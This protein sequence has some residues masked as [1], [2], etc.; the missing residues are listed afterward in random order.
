MISSQNPVLSLA[1]PSLQMAAASAH[2]AEP[3]TSEAPW[4]SSVPSPPAPAL[5]SH[6]VLPVSLLSKHSLVRLLL[7]LS[8]TTTLWV[9]TIPCRNHCQQ[10]HILS[11]FYIPSF[12]PS[13][14]FSSCSHSLF[15]LNVYQPAS[16]FHTLLPT[17][18]SYKPPIYVT[19]HMLRMEGIL[20]KDLSQGMEEFQD[21][22]RNQHQTVLK[23]ST[24][25]G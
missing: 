1:L 23:G 14:L 19:Y 17:Q 16:F 10:V 22:G 3:E 20:K 21:F 11:Y 2:L 9:S 13:N 18:E 8:M 7:S 12:F 25:R 6:H 5:I 15:A 24:G 4:A